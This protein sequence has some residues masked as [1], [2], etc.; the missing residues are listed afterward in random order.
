[1]NSFRL[2]AVGNLARNPELTTKGDITFARFCLTGT[3]YAG[4]S[5]KD[6]PREFVTS[7]WFIAFGE[8]AESIAR[9]SRKGDQLI[10][11]ARIVANSWIDKDGE[12][13][14][15]H[16]FIVTGFLFGATSGGHGSPIARRGE[17]PHAPLSDANAAKAEEEE[18]AA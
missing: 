8:I 16:T 11:E 14:C 6:G 10:L 5:E 2:T 4:E 13:Q 12:R 9:H 7:L 17:P 3:D 15:G 1:M 18:M